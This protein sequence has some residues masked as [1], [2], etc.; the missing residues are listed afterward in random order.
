MTDD[1]LRR[2]YLRAEQVTAHWA[3]RFYFAS[4]FLPPAKKRAIFAIYDYCRHTDNLVDQR[5]D[6]PV[7]EVRADA[8]AA[9][10]H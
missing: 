3:K 6:R 9:H 7:G 5:G 4:R 1:A 8:P 2:S 10:S